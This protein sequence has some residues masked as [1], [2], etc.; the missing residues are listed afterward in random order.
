MSQILAGNSMP[1]KFNS[2]IYF[3]YLET[4]SVCLSTGCMAAKQLYSTQRLSL[5]FTITT[6]SLFAI[7]DGVGMYEDARI[8][9]NVADKTCSSVSFST[10]KSLPSA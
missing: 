10:L 1:E 7:L 8:G 9:L 5:L 4:L 2:P 6:A 3:L